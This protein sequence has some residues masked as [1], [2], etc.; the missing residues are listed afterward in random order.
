M[1]VFLGGLSSA[2]WRERPSITVLVALVI[3]SDWPSLNGV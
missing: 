2:L 1:L 3:T